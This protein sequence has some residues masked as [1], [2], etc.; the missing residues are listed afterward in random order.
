MCASS[1]IIGGENL[2]T[3]HVR[4]WS[5]NAPESK[6]VNEYGPTETVVGC[7]VYTLNGEES[8]GVIPIG[9]PI[10]NMKL[11][12]LDEFLEP[13][14][15]GVPGELFIG[16]VGVGRGYLN[17]PELTAERFIPN[18]FSD[19]GKLYK[20]GDRARWLSN[21]NLE[22]LGRLDDQVKVRGFRIELGEIEA[23][24]SK[25]PG[26]K[27]CVVWVH[28]EGSEQSVKTK[29]LVGYIVPGAE[30]Q[31]P[32]HN[33]INNYL[34]KE[35]PEYM[36]PSTYIIMERLPLTPNGKVDR[37]VLPKPQADLSK[38]TEFESPSTEKEKILAGIWAEVLGKE[39]IGV[40]DNFFELGGD[41][42]LTIQVVARAGNKGLRISARQM[43]EAQT[44][45][46]LAQV[47]EEGVSIIAEQGPVTGKVQLT[48]IQEW[49]FQQGFE[50]PWHWNQSLLLEVTKNLN[51]DHLR[52]AMKNVLE[53]HDALRMVFKQ[54]ISGVWEGEILGPEMDIPLSFVMLAGQNEEERVLAL[55]NQVEEI[56]SSL[57]LENGPV[58]RVVYFDFGEGKGGR[59]LIVVHHLVMDGVSWRI[60]M[61]DILGAYTSAENGLPILLPLKTTS[62]KE[63]SARMNDYSRAPEVVQ[64]LEFWS[65]SM[66]IHQPGI[67]VNNA[68]GINSEASTEK[69]SFSLTNEESR[70]LLQEI[71]SIFGTEINDILLTALAYAIHKWAGSNHAL[72][73]LEGHGREE[74]FPDIDINRT[75]GWFTAIYPASIEVKQGSSV[76][77]LLKSVKEQLRAIPQKG[78][79]YGLLKYINQTVGKVLKEVK[80][81]QIIFNYLGQ[82]DK[83]IS[84]NP[85]FHLAKENSGS[86]RPLNSKR[87]YLLEVTGGVLSNCMNI[88]I[89]FSSNIHERKMIDEFS[90]KFQMALQELI[91]DRYSVQTNVYTPSDFNLAGL[92]QVNLDKIMK[93]VNRNK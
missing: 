67:P 46:R 38:S 26:V 29:R 10:A 48:P 21:G 79:G 11:Y 82:F 74:I 57:N 31:K 8:I 45:R 40:N 39:H 22:C 89:A 68:N 9:K 93:K 52:L 36:L 77:E 12:V 92:D 27:E 2:T 42:I 4:F 80:E 65:N 88:E 49:F 83:I 50:E 58:F 55:E 75:I 81:P 44:I 70:I 72:I 76:V 1:F 37:K 90:L 20:T 13:L 69:V 19:Q 61:E 85:R 73:A 51:I 64:Q 54:S 6:L 5:N 18:P 7:C 25:V 71:P 63:W 15:I 60:L 43:F 62:F 30:Q 66:N 32:D 86:S 3:D 47:A 33:S 34:S 91:K 78:L 28:E 84:D 41:S 56:Q 14:P 17:R 87:Q 53:H 59:L 35:L 16:G 23:V 24:L